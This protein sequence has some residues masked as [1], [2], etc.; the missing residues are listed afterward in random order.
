MELI[1]STPYLKY[2]SQNVKKNCLLSQ[3]L[4]YNVGKKV[5]EGGRWIMFFK[6]TISDKI[7]GTASV[8]SE[9]VPSAQ[10]HF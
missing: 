1:G 9:K 10:V 7:S 3:K 6:V 8:T 4:W 5:R 2:T